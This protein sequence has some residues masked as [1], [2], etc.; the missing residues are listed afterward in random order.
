[1]TSALAPLLL[2]MLSVVAGL[3]ARW[4]PASDGG[5]ARFSKRY[6]DAAGIDDSRWTDDRASSDSGWYP[7]VLPDT[8]AGWFGAIILAVLL[9]GVYQTQQPRAQF[10]GG[11]AGGGTAGGSGAPLPWGRSSS[12]TDASEAARAAF[13]KKYDKGS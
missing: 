6:R 1:M 7:S 2:A 9:Y 13:L 12:A 5:P 4:T 3:E 8:P 11:T 10:V